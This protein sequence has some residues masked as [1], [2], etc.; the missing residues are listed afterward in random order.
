MASY[1]HL[2]LS[3]CFSLVFLLAICHASILFSGGTVIA[4]ERETETLQIVRNG[5]VLVDGNKIAAVFSGSYNGSA[6]P[7]TEIIDISGDIISTGFI[8]THR[9]GSQTAFKT[10][11]SNTSLAEYINRYTAFAPGIGS[12]FTAEDVY[13]GQLAGY[14]EALN[15]GVTTIVDYAHHTWTN[16]TAGAGLEAAIESGAR[17]F[18]CYGFVDSAKFTITDQVANVRELAASRTTYNS[19]VSLGIGYEGFN[20]GRPEAAQMIIDLAREFNI[21]VVTTHASLGQYGCK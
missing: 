14:Y 15:A 7:V 10:L 8:D 9:H 12:L 16:A 17:I 2:H 3:L 1:Q 18:W 11:G 6:S 20:P 21:S 4:F 19:I 13:I 5:S